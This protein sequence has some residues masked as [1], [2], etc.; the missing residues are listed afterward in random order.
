M[1]KPLFETEKQYRGEGEFPD[2]TATKLPP[3]SKVYIVADSPN[4]AAV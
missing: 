3:G 2:M 4:M 1:K